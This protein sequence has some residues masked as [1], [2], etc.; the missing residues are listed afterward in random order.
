M[1]TLTHMDV[2]TAEE[3]VCKDDRIAL[4]AVASTPMRAK[5]A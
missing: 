1:K 3:G 2:H 5:S 4:G